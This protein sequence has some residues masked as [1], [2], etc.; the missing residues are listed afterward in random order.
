[1]P[2]AAMMLPGPP[3]PYLFL[4]RDTEALAACKNSSRCPSQKGFKYNK[5]GGFPLRHSQRL[6]L[7]RFLPYPA[8]PLQ[9]HTAA[10]STHGNH[11]FLW[12]GEKNKERK[13]IFFPPAASVGAGWGTC[14][15]VMA[16]VP[17]GLAQPPAGFP[18]ADR[19]CW[20]VRWL[21]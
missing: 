9:K 21:K 14:S 8:L 18:S 6:R 10:L 7:K 13:K 17:Q 2:A 20:W 4:F 5:P 15:G 1:M 3:V 16:W 12:R 19:V 11:S